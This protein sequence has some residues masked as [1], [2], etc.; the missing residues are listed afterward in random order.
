MSQKSCKG[1]NYSEYYANKR[2][3]CT[4]NS[5]TCQS[6]YVPVTCQSNYVPVACSES[7]KPVYDILIGKE[8]I[9]PIQTHCSTTPVYDILADHTEC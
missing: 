2:Y 1:L 6:N 7:C 5:V 9:I 4:S 3:E 8:K